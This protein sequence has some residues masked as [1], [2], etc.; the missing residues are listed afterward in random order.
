MKTY[1][2]TRAYLTAYLLYRTRLMHKIS[3]RQMHKYVDLKQSTYAKI[4]TGALKLTLDNFFTVLIMM[5]FTL[6]T[7]EEMLKKIDDVINE[8]IDETKPSLCVGISEDEEYNPS[9]MTEEEKARVEHTKDVRFF[10]DILGAVTTAKI[11][12]LLA[13]HY[14]KGYENHFA[15]KL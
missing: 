13:E 3:L 9:T 6:T 1:L 14:A 12:L 7:Y 10:D 5:G 15:K 11:D 2:T 4:E 8:G